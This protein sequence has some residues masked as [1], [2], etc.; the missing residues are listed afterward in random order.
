M[1]NIRQNIHVTSN[2]ADSPIEQ[3]HRLHLQCP[4]F[5][6]EIK[7][8]YSKKADL[9][10]E[11]NEK[12]VDEQN[13]FHKERSTIDLIPSLTN[14]IETRQKKRLPTFCAFIDFKKA[15]TR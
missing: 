6:F 7:V 15:F 11:E 12:L 14:L 2:A 13:G 1:A 8:L 5:Q 10:V 3:L 9:W 4:P